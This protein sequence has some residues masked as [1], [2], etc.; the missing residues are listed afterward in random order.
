VLVSDTSC[1][2]EHHAEFA[3]FVIDQP[4]REVAAVLDEFPVAV[5]DG[6]LQHLEHLA[7][8]KL[9]DNALTL[10]GEV[11]IGHRGSRWGCRSDRLGRCLEQL[12]F[13]ILLHIR[14]HLG[15]RLGDLT[16]IVI[17]IDGEGAFALPGRRTLRYG[18]CLPTLARAAS[19]SRLRS[20][21]T[22][23]RGGGG[24]GFGVVCSWSSPNSISGAYDC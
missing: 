10:L 1:L 12:V 16:V 22:S 20:A 14:S 24:G 4:D 13:D 9:L 21:S 17:K 18:Y 8:D 7:P 11:L 5:G 19:I 2:P 6:S 3:V 15:S 23:A